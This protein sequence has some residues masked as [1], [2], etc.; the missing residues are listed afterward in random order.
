MAS[1][2]SLILCA[3][4]VTATVSSLA[5]AAN[6]YKVGDADGWRVPGQN[7]SDMYAAWADKHVFHVGD[8][9]VFEYKNDSVLR[10]SKTEYYH[11]NETAGGPT[12]KDGTT[13][14]VLDQPGFYYY[15][16][17]DVEHCKRGQR[18]MIRAVDGGISPATDIA[19]APA[20]A[21]DSSSTVSWRMAPIH[22][23]AALISA[24]IF[25]ACS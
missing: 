12:P 25:V 20:P 2:N 3:L 24:L 8:S 15:V 11:C 10:S 13:V 17:S 19:A 9:I 5:A 6:L 14:F 7:D 16:S 22:E 18:V 23:L 21:P 4:L 1:L